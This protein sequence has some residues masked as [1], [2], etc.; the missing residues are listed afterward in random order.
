MLISSNYINYTADGCKVFD[1]KT[2]SK[3][4]A[5]KAHSRV[6][7][8]LYADVTIKSRSIPKVFNCSTQESRKM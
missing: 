8:L 2:S 6:F 7:T 3:Y 5:K 4:V 1:N